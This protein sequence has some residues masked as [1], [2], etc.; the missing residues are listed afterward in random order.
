MEKVRLSRIERK[1][2]FALRVYD[3]INIGV[4]EL[5]GYLHFPPILDILEALDRL[6]KHGFIRKVESPYRGRPEHYVITWEGKEWLRFRPFADLSG[7]E[8]KIGL[9]CAF[10]GVLFEK[11]VTCFLG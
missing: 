4:C 5:N 11:A 10:A 8:L 1:I 7:K 3:E 9:L 6:Q 2:L